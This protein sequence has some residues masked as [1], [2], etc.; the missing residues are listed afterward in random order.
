MTAYLRSYKITRGGGGCTKRYYHGKKK[1]DGTIFFFCAEHRKCLGFAFLTSPESADTVF[2]ILWTRFNKLPPVIV[3]DNG[4][5]LSEYILNREPAW[6]KDILIVV[7]GLHIQGHVNCS[8][9]YDSRAYECCK[10]IITVLAEQKNAKTTVIRHNVSFM[11]LGLFA[12]SMAW[13]VDRLNRAEENAHRT[14]LALS[15]K[16]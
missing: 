16:E 4:C 10:R 5:N 12:L 13:F 6:I 11:S 8:R 2:E 15:R 1:G 9:A 14:R 3:Y 7:D